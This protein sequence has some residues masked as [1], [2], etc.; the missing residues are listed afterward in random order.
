M[1]KDALLGALAAHYGE[2]YSA[3]ETDA[4][5]LPLSALYVM[6]IADDRYALFRQFVTGKAESNDFVYAFTP[7]VLTPKLAKSCVDFALGD[8]SARIDPTGD[9]MFSL[10]TVLFFSGSIDAAAAA[11][12]KKAKMHRNYKPPQTGWAEL[13]TAAFDSNGAL[14]AANSMGRDVAVMLKKAIAAK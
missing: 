4:G 14:I 8:G 10:I 5:T 2:N 6:H 1:T 12:I 9:H 7:D 13:R 3:E 11:A